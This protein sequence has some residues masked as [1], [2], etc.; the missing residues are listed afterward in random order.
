M[1]ASFVPLGLEL[2]PDVCGAD[3]VAENPTFHAVADGL[4]PSMELRLSIAFWKALN[5]TADLANSDR[6][7]IE[8]ALMLV[9]P[10]N[11][12]GFRPGLDG[13]AINV[14]IDEIAHNA[15]GSESSQSRS[16][17]SKAAGQASKRSTKP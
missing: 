4:K 10:L 2:S 5:A 16:G 15:G 1:D 17:I 6:A 7:H 14:R 8:F 11:D 13:L 12:L 9:E 3:V